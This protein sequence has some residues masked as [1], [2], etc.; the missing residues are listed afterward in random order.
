MAIGGDLKE[1]FHKVWIIKEDC[2]SQRFL[3][4]GIETIQIDT[5]EMN[6]MIFGAVSSPYTAH[7]V[8]NRNAPK[9]QM[10]Y[11]DACDA[12]VNTHYMDDYYDSVDTVEEAIQRT[13]DVIYVHRQGG[14]EVRNWT[15]NSEEVL[16]S[17][18]T[19]AV[20]PKG[21]SLVLTGENYTRLLG[22]RWSP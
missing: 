4:R 11:P 21:T 19:S 6:V 13:K 15:S 8:R 7:E 3:W 1:M 17:P 18:D 22:V 14:F 20:A 10:I 12:V 5:L 16:N 9:F 2:S